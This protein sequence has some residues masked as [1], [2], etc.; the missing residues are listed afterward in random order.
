MGHLLGRL[1]AF[2]KRLTA[3][4]TKEEVGIQRA[5]AVVTGNQ[6]WGRLLVS[7]MVD[8]HRLVLP[9]KRA[10]EGIGLDFPA[11]RG[12]DNRGRLQM[13]PRGPLFC[14][15][16]AAMGAESEPLLHFLGTM[17]AIKFLGRRGQRG[18]QDLLILLG[19]IGAGLPEFGHPF[20]EF[21]GDLRQSFRPEEDQGQNQKENDLFE[22]NTDQE[23][24]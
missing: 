13:L 7:V 11:A 24:P 23:P 6:G 18:I 16:L 2:L 5:A 8:F 3:A 9:A 21:F 10:K 1:Q 15:A 12:A 22:G 20:A 4:G 19:E 14:L 17:D